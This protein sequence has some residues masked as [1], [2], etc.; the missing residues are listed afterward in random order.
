[1][2]LIF[3]CW[4]HLAVKYTV[5]CDSWWTDPQ[6]YSFLL[7]KHMH[8]HA[9]KH[10]HTFHIWNGVIICLLSRHIALSDVGGNRLVLM[11]HI[12]SLKFK[13]LNESP[14]THTHTHTFFPLPPFQLSFSIIFLLHKFIFN[15]IHQQS[16]LVDRFSRASNTSSLP[17]IS[18]VI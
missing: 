8:V 4:W 3:F 9:H 7:I 1:M 16:Y 5:K 13:Y 10:W 17:Y 12:N 11:S 2:I 15:H 6:S 18:V 14:P